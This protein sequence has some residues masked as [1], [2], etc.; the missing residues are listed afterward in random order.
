MQ[1][2]IHVK[3]Q[4]TSDNIGVSVHC[5]EIPHGIR[6]ST[7]TFNFKKIKISPVEWKGIEIDLV[8]N[9]FGGRL[10]Y[11]NC[12]DVAYMHGIKLSSRD[13]SNLLML[14]QSSQLPPMIPVKTLFRYY[15]DK[16]M[17]SS[18]FDISE[19]YAAGWKDIELG[20]GNPSSV[21]Q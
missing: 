3:T 10:Y 13:V 12:Y 17:D 2:D 21:Q 15:I 20:R 6:R 14:M 8:C 5:N 1:P 4:G 7:H 18:H 11:P 16:L 19:L 9:C